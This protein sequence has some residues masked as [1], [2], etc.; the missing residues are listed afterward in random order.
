MYVSIVDISTG[1][2]WHVKFSEYAHFYAFLSH[3]G[4]NEYSIVNPYTEYPQQDVQYIDIS[5]NVEQ[6]EF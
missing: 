2:V 6:F 4:C 3:H 5:E 1:Q